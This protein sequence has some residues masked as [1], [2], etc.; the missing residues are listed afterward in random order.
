MSCPP[1][2][3]CSG[4]LS[5]RLSLF[6]LLLDVKFLRKRWGKKDLF[7][8]DNCSATSL[9]EAHLM[10]A[11]PCAQLAARLVR[12]QFST[13]LLHF[14][15]LS[16]NVFHFTVANWVYTHWAI[17]ECCACLCNFSLFSLMSFSHKANRSI[18]ETKRMCEVVKSEKRKSRF[19]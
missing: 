10:L 3:A 13:F 6:H 14:R 9:V 16:C 5:S 17:N 19:I 4:Q 18:I 15:P 7:R 1:L 8:R 11:T 2:Q 12:L